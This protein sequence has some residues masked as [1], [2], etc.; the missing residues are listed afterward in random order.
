MIEQYEL[1]GAKEVLEFLTKYPGYK[2]F[3][4][5][6]YSYRGAKEREVD[7]NYLKGSLGWAAASDVKI[8][9]K[10]KE[11]HVNGFSDNDLD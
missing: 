5:A 1:V 3:W 4:Q 7:R 8:D 11:I 2:T 6:G 9:H 10:T